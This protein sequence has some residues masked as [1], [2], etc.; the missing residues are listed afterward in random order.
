[1]A[2]IVDAFN[3]SLNENLAFVK[4]G[5]FAIP[6]YFIAKLFVVGNTQ[7]FSF[8]G[9]IVGLLFLALLTVGINNVRRNRKEILSFNFVR[10]GISLL[11]ALVVLVPQVFLFGSLGY[12]L[13]T[14]VVIPVELPQFQLIYS[15][16]IWA[17]VF[18][19]IL[20]SYL[21]FAKYL[22]ILQGYNYKIIFE[23][24]IDVLI[25]FFFFIPQ[26]LLANI[27][28][29]GPVVYL[30]SIFNLPFEHWGFI[31]YCSVTIV[32]NI[33]ILANYLAQASYEQIKGNNEEYDENVQMNV[34]DVASERM[35]GR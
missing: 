18:A 17:I 29:L 30:F 22:K 23:S 11:K 13:T 14:Q 10:L 7:A 24:C 16:L 1:M 4:I 9:S 34:V 5:V 32:I 31:A 25:S 6:T 19:I 20:T 15:I 27:V 35:N 21:S 2:S 8:W 28:L 26:L 3:D 12:C 33:S